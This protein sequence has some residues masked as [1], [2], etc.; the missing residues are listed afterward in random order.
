MAQSFV[1]RRCAVIHARHTDLGQATRPTIGA[2]GILAPPPRSALSR[3]RWPPSLRPPPA[4]HDCR[5]CQL[6][7]SKSPRVAGHT[8]LRADAS[9][10]VPASPSGPAGGGSPLLGS[11]AR[12]ETAPAADDLLADLLDTAPPSA[13]PAV[14]T[15]LGFGAVA[16]PPPPVPVRLA[17]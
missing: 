7:G 10:S 8:T 13:P 1:R 4:S 5:P 2:G 16:G 3:G 17:V 6:A 14:P 12:F 9:P 15:A 11:P